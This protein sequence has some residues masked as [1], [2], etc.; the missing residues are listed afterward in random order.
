MAYYSKVKEIGE[1]KKQIPLLKNPNGRY[2][3]INY[4]NGE[5]I[6]DYS[7]TPE[8]IEKRRKSISE[9]WDRGCYDHVDQGV[10][11]RGK[12][13]EEVV[14]KEKAEEVSDKL[15]KFATKRNIEIQEKG[16]QSG[17]VAR[18][19]PDSIPYI[20]ELADELGITDLRHGL[21]KDVGEFYIE[22]PDGKGFY[23]VDGYS[24]EKI[25]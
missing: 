21:T 13:W 15:S 20:E 7:H 16:G 19:N 2:E 14:G 5:I 23:A 10:T 3:V 1:L 9:A 22:K 12:T 4:K 18:I 8:A 25:L 17:F 11:F 6:V 24:E